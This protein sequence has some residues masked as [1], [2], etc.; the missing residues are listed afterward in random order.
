VLCVDDE[1]AVLDGLARS[2]RGQLDLTTAT[3]GAAGLEILSGQG[4]FA[5]VLA[6]LHMPGMDG[7]AFLQRARE[8]APHAVPVLLTGETDLHTAMGAVN[9]AHIFGFLSKP[10]H[11]SSLLQALQAAAAQHRLLVED[12]SKQAQLEE[13]LRQAQK[14]EAIGQLAGGVAH[15]FNNLLTVINGFSGVVLG[16]LALD[17]PLRDPV[18]QIAK[19]GERAAQLTQQL[20]AFSRRQPLAPQELDPR[21]VVVDLEKMLRRLIGED[22]ELR[23]ALQPGTGCVRVDGGQLQQ[24]VLNL[25][26][27]ARDAMPGGGQITIELT[28]VDL[29][30]GYAGQ[31][32]MPA[33]P[34]V[35]L[36]VT[37]TGH[38]M[39][40]ATQARI[41]EP[42][43]TTK[44]PG[45][46][47][48][49]GLSTV[50]GIVKQSGGDVWVHSEPGQGTTFKVYLPRVSSAA[51][52]AGSL[53]T[54]L[55]QGSET[56][57]VVEDA[58]AVRALITRVLRETGYTVLEAE[59]G[60]RAL[61]VVADHAGP[62]HLL[63][64]DVIMPGMSGLDLVARLEDLRPGT[65]A[66]YMSGYTGDAIV[67]HGLFE[68][69]LHLLQKPFSAATLAGAVR[70]V[71]DA[72]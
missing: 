42:F 33:G 40:A 16:Q 67:R 41:F 62:I 13:H 44:E 48:G 45:K 36:A 30:D 35:M 7:I 34:Y 22:V 25:V 54:T 17:D 53:P 5:V 69:G 59:S 37:D 71:L 3:S 32:P 57:L 56:L 24:V 63:L 11:R 64:T 20:L 9:E 12:E 52:A 60:D 55:P 23:I 39:D 4:P 65:R 21:E 51:P 58:D 29:D 31:H 66:L 10:C 14:M 18:E 6:D 50:Y 27:N 1:P 26:V 46:G 49:L 2:L 47:T 38:G 61:A 70:A 72:A 8:L 28:E 19:A 68:P 15:D 43:F